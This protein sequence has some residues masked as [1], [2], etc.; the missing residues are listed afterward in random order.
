MCY[1][2]NIHT[3]RLTSLPPLSPTC[4]SL[5]ALQSGGCPRPPQ[6]LPSIGLFDQLFRYL[7]VHLI[8]RLI[9]C[10]IIIYLL[11]FSCACA[12]LDRA[13]VFCFLFHFHPST[14]VHTR[15]ATRKFSWRF[16]PP[17]K[18]CLVLPPW[19]ALDRFIKTFFLEFPKMQGIFLFHFNPIKPGTFWTF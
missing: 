16:L 18:G 13:A 17:T 14:T 8:I 7:I 10:L 6:S 4:P 3:R 15:R 11:V 12:S 9:I 19:C 5:P 2:E 1:F